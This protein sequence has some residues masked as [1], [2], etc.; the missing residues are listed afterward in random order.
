MYML[1]VCVCV[2][3]CVHVWSYPPS[4]L[5]SPPLYCQGRHGSFGLDKLLAMARVRGAQYAR[6]HVQ[7]CKHA[8]CFKDLAICVTQAEGKESSL[9]PEARVEVLEDGAAREREA[10]CTACVHESRTR[11]R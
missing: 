4:Y 6:A 1:C 8:A 9:L 7:A 11:R 2:H 3:V 5:A 10:E